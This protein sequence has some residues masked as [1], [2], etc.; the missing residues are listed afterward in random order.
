MPILRFDHTH[1]YAD[2]RDT[3]IIVPV[4]LK[5]G[6]P[7]VRIAA[8]LDTGATFCI[9]EREH[10]EDGLGFNIEAGARTEFRTATNP[11][12]A[13]GHEVTFSSFG[14]E[15]V[16]TVYF[17]ESQDFGRNVS[18]RRGWIHRF[19]MAIIEDDSILHLSHYDD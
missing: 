7:A 17:A 6:A 15:F 18:G 10:G 11:F 16:S 14:R 13:Y 3:G 9:F 4:E 5:V 1:N 12:W 19:R 8:S 2:R